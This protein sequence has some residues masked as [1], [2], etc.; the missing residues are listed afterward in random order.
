MVLDIDDII[1]SQVFIDFQKS[2]VQFSD[3]MELNHTM[4]GFNFIENEILS[5]KF[6]YI[7][8]GKLPAAEFFPIPELQN[9][10]D[11]LIPI[12]SEKHLINKYLPGGGLTLT[13]KFDNNG[14]ARKGLF[15]RL[16]SDN[17]TLKANA[18]KIYSQFHLEDED[19]EDGFGQYIML[20]GAEIEKSRY[21]YMKNTGK[22]KKLY[23][24]PFDITTSIEL[25][26]I[27]TNGTKE[28]KLIAIGTSEI[29]T[30]EFY[31]SM[32]KTIQKLKRTNLVC[33]SINLHTKERSIY[34]FSLCK[35]E[36]GF[37]NLYSLT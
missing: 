20:Q 21:V 4:L 8:F 29:I 36:D 10:Y 35:R 22:I 31:Q 25:S 15:L 14:N 30:D 23:D 17:A 19:F 24:I 3:E 6:Y 11:K 32:P 12:S 5:T 2:M 13:I 28:S 33:P 34:Y 16:K 9:E 18:K 1:K 7:F 27:E 26:A 37:E